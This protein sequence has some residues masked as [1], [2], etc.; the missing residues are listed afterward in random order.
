MS[1]GNPYDVLMS[2]DDD[3]DQLIDMIDGDIDWGA[4]E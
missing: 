1:S 4:E 2:D 3:D